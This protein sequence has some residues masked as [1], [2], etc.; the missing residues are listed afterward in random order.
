M[1]EVPIE[2]VPPGIA[3]LGA[4]PLVL[5]AE[6]SPRVADGRLPRSGTP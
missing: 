5:A 1:E 6:P 4:S 3:A 2:V